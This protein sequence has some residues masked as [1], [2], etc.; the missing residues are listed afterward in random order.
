M[1]PLAVRRCR[2][3]LTA[4]HHRRRPCLRR[5]QPCGFDYSINEIL[6]VNSAVA[7]GRMCAV[8]AVSGLFTPLPATF[9]PDMS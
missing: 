8:A 3:R 2:G 1:P 9:A 7:V 4:C 5:P 6:V